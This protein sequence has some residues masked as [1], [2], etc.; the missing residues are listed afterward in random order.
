MKKIIGLLIAGLVYSIFPGSAQTIRP[1]WENHKVLE[2][3]RLPARA[4]FVPFVEERL[5]RSMSLNGSWKFNY[6]PKVEEAPLF[7]FQN[8]YDDAN[9]AEIGR[10]HV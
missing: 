3:N 2:I 9:W 10:A 8:D 6:V 5:D 1:P 4:S 7:F